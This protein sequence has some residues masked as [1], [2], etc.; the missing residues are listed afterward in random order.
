MGISEVAQRAGIPATTLRYYE[1]I[2]LIAAPQRANGRRVYDTSIFEVL[3][4]IRLAK[5]SGFSLREIR[6]LVSEPGD[7]TAR[8]RA[9]AQHK[10]VEVQQ[11]IAAYQQMQTTLKASIACA[12]S[13]WDDCPLLAP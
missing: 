3:A 12:C 10:L 4:L 6:Q 8:W 13:G 5:Q 9:A 1:K 11:T 2:G 7:P